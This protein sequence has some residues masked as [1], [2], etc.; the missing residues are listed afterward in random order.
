MILVGVLSYLQGFWRRLARNS[1]KN[2]SKLIAVMQFIIAF[3]PTK[4][5]MIQPLQPG[6]ETWGKMYEIFRYFVPPAFLQTLFPTYIATLN[7]PTKPA[8]RFV[9]SEG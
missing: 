6:T 9:K 7:L 2:T 3:I 4:V 1:T 5:T 8:S